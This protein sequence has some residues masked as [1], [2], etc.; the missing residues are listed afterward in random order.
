[1][2]QIDITNPEV[3]DALNRLNEATSHLQPVLDDIGQH[4]ASEVDLNFS[5]TKDPYGQPWKPLSEATVSRRRNN[6]NK[7]LNDTGVLKNSITYHADNQGVV[8]G[9]N[10]EYAITHQLGASKGQYAPGIP[11]GNIPARPFLPTA[12]KGLPDD[13]EDDILDIITS[14]LQ[15]AI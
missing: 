1:M 15:R 2:I 14:H 10:M 8:I 5:D 4:I 7:P 9:T 11:W 12:A 13:W 3:L 6:S